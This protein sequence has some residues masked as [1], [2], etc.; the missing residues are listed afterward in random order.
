MVE[1]L[2]AGL[3][4]AVLAVAALCTGV[5]GAAA[6]EPAPTFAFVSDIHFDPFAPASLTPLLAASAVAD[7]PARFAAIDDQTLATWGSDTNHALLVSSLAAIA[8]TASGA[9]FVVAP[10]DFLSHD[11]EKHAAEA[12]GVAETSAAVVDLAVRTTDFVAGS[13]AAALPGKPVIV[14]LGNNDSSCG[15]YRIEPGG[16]YL[17]ETAATVRRLVGDGLVDADFDATYAAG[18]YY[19]LRHPTLPKHHIVVLNDVLWSAKYQNACGTGGSA[20]AGVML[21]WL[22]DRLARLEADGE[23]VWMVHHIPWGIDAYSTDRASHSACPAEV[24]PFMHAAFADDFVALLRRYAG[25]VTASFSGHIHFDGYRLVTDAAGAPIGVDKVAPGISP[26]FGQNPGFQVFAYDRS[27]GLPTDFS[28][29]YLANLGPAL[30][31]DD[32]DWRFEYTFSA[33]YGQ[34]GYS[35]AAVAAMAKAMAGPGVV[36]DT[37]SRLYN[38]SHGSLGAAGFA[39]YVCAIESIEPGGFDT[40][41]CGG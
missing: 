6:A 12:L 39:A 36:R 9:D 3:R 13:L 7:W 21:A 41:Y 5:G 37:F 29:F 24:V 26:I 14:A 22:K 2:A 30:A 23:H 27:S 15:D 38:V 17:A 33:A 31:P 25:T 32:A 20:A 34:P 1:W 16:R 40:C 11:F 4:P 18:G 28:T 19:S 10:G 35:V 8:G